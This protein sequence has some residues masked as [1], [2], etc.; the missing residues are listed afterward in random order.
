MHLLKIK[1]KSWCFSFP[2]S[3]HFC[4]PPSVSVFSLGMIKYYD[5]KWFRFQEDKSSLL[6][7]GMTA[8]GRRGKL[9][10][11][12]RKQPK[13]EVGWSIDTRIYAHIHKSSPQYIFIQ[14]GHSFYTLHTAPLTRETCLNAW[15]SQGYCSFKIP[16]FTLPAFYFC[17][18][19]N[20]T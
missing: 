16:L 7:G 15:S 19:D 1:K 2:P 14:Q 13:L 9:R 10:D 5:P 4:L 11:H 18:T 6:W 8:R 12:S 20:Q 3:L 17:D